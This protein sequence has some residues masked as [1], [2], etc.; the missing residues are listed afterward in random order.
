M[1]KRCPWCGKK[2][3]INRWNRLRRK[4]PSRFIFERCEFCGQYYGQRSRSPRVISLCFAMLFSCFLPLLWSPLIY[5]VIPLI[6]LLAMVVIQIPLERMTQDENFH[7]ISRPIFK[8][9]ILWDNFKI[10]KKHIYVQIKGFDNM[11]AFLLV[12]PI[13][14]T[15]VDKKEGEISF[16]FLYDHEKNTRSSII[17]LYDGELKIAEIKIHDKA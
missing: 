7:K 1:Q 17:T 3:K 6:F 12:S 13:F 9:K 8:A 16:Y 10:R 2:I 14:V 5:L 11:N 4:T 15:E